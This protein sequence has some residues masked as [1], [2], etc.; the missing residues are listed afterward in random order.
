MGELRQVS[1]ESSI[2]PA[3]ILRAQGQ[4]QRQ[5]QKEQLQIGCMNIHLANT[6]KRQSFKEVKRK[7]DICG[8]VETWLRRSNE[9]MEAEL[10][11]TDWVWVGKDRKGRSGGGLG[12]RGKKELSPKVLKSRCESIL[13]VQAGSLFVAVV[14][15]IPKDSDGINTIALEELEAD[16]LRRNREGTVVVLGDFNSRVGELANQV[17][18]PGDFDSD[19]VFL[20]RKSVDKKKPDATGKRL[21]ARMNAS[22]MVLVNG[23][24]GEADW[25]SFHKN[26]NAVIDLAWVHVNQLD[27]VTAM[28]VW[29]HDFDLS[30]HALISIA[31]SQPKKNDSSVR[32]PRDANQGAKR[33]WNVNI[34]K[35]QWE[36]YKVSGQQLFDFWRPEGNGDEIWADWKDRVKK[37]QKQPSATDLWQNR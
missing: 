35:E 7:L 17:S 11:G 30:D 34:S 14:Y 29:D 16:I 26:G 12:L 10:L 5:I 6:W 36:R 22:G 18:N 24:F 19:M 21:L 25:T 20:N 4:L 37:L 27:N 32:Q 28:K 23:I 13:W 1:A 33:R 9:T 2:I 15:L 8:V 31:L 3:K